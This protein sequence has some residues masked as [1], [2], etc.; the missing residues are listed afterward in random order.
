MPVHA[1][2]LPGTA[3][4]HLGVPAVEIDAADLRMGWRRHADIARRTDVEIQ[5]VVRPDRQKFPPMRRIARQIVIDGGRLRRVVE[6]VG[7]IVDL[8]DLVDFGDIERAV[9]ESDAVGR[10]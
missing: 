4:D 9:V 2:D 3:R 1:D 6:L 5:L 7:D 10:V 8:R